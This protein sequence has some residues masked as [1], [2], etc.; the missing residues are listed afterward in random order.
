[1]S[2]PDLRKSLRAD[3]ISRYDTGHEFSTDKTETLDENIASVSANIRLNIYYPKTPA[4]LVGRFVPSIMDGGVCT[5]ADIPTDQLDQWG[6][7]A[8]AKTVPTAPEAGV[9]SAFIELREGLPKLVGASLAKNGLKAKGLPKAVGNEFLNVEFGYK[10][11][12][13]DIV[14]SALAVVDF[15][16]RLAQLR[17]DSE[18]VVRRR[19]QLASESTA[20]VVNLTGSNVTGPYLPFMNTGT[21]NVN[22]TSEVIYSKGA[23]IRLEEYQNDVWF[24]GAYTYYLHQGQEFHD[25]VREYA[26]LA[27]SLLG[28]DLSPE[29]VW[30]VTP[31]S[32]L[33]DWFADTNVFMR[34]ITELQPDSSVL[35]YGYVMSTQKTTWT[36]IV[37]NIVPQVGASCPSSSSVTRLRTIKQRR[38]ATPYG[39]GLDIGG[40]SSR[41]WSILGALG[42]SKSDRALKP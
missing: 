12:V 5:M 14:K 11:L 20:R 3:Y 23:P 9:M 8:I 28:A 41:R 29:T 40:F 13:G 17:K 37:P 34:N 22:M 30:Q 25:K 4:V 42:M 15:E 26:Q 38:K 31:W 21:G 7:A 19:A 24:A 2:G 18:Q 36:Y 1:M 27:H 16:K 35:R 32:W 39:F 33:L 10:P 6:R